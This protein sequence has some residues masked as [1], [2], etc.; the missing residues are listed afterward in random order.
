[1]TE[2]TETPVGQDTDFTVLKKGIGIVAFV[3]AI[4][5]PVVG[6][7]ANIAVLIWKKGSGESTRLPIWGIV[8]SVVLII[9]TIVVGLIALSLFTSAANAGAVNIE[10]LCVH[11]DQ[12][13]WLIDSLRYVCR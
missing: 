9:A 6:L 11:R 12:W 1:M 10:A 4:V 3:L 2:T 7:V 13:G 5:M 8:V